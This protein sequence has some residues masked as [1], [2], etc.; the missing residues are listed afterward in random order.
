MKL[1]EL[2]ERLQEYLHLEDAGVIDITLAST[3]ATR[4][5]IGNPVWLVVIGVS[6]GGKS[7]I[8]RPLAG[9]DKHVHRVDDLS[10]NTLI[11]GM[12]TNETSL[13][14]KIGGRGIIV[15]SD[16]TVLFSKNAEARN[17]I[18]G[19]LRLVYDGE[20]T[21][22][23]GNQKPVTWKGELGVIAGCTPSV[24]RHFEEVADMGERFIYYRMRP[25]DADK[26][27][28]KALS[29]KLYGKELDAAIAELF[30]EYQKSVYESY[31]E[32]A[33]PTLSPKVIER[34][35]KISMF[36]ARLRTPISLDFKTG[37]V[38]RIPSPEMPMR[39]ALQLSTT[40][41]MLAIMEYHESGS[42][43]LKERALEELEW[44]GYSLANEERRGVLRT[45]CGYAYG[46]EI[47]TAVI[48]DAI[49]FETDMAGRVLHHLAAMK[50]VKRRIEQGGHLWCI[51]EE[52]EWKMV[53]RL[54]RIFA[55]EEEPEDLGIN[56]DDT[57]A[58]T[59]ELYNNLE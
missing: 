3:L 20:M 17:A 55:I 33:E 1:A 19:Q 54:E 51:A 23:F 56:P 15:I 37:H 11:S 35:R 45:L 40:A 31:K 32:C 27:V 52:S 48:A 7:Q 5:T 16:L 53:R 47:R 18:L 28:L 10:E 4:I 2:K 9:R 49:G 46:T 22:H 59:D 57:S 12:K 38:D 29:N 41:K 25:F 24:Y 8:L 50:L 44:C 30:E 58:T 21:K 42:F 39:V 34:I 26:A 14:L 13:L 6:S 43:E 36:A